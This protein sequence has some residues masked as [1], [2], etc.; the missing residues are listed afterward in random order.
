MPVRFDNI[1]IVVKVGRRINSY[2]LCKRRP[3]LEQNEFAYDLHITL[4]TFDWFDRIQEVEMEMPHPPNLPKPEVVGV[5]V[6]KDTPTK[7]M[8]RLRDE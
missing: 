3:K 2:R 4:N 1:Y 8:D 7:V 6:E 5:L